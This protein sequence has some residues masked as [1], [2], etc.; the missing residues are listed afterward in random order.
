MTLGSHASERLACGNHF[1]CSMTAVLLARIDAHGG[2]RAVRELLE[3]A[4]INRSPEYLRD[5]GNWIS[6]GE[7]VFPNDADCAAG[8]LRFA[9][10]AM[11]GAKRRSPGR[12]DQR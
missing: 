4:A 6:Y 5:T 7:A 12:K 2:A 3:R 10:T 11:F 8:L 9:D 1:S